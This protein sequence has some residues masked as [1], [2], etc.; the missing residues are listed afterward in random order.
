MLDLLKFKPMQIPVGDLTKTERAFLSGINNLEL[1]IIKIT[2]VWA[3]AIFLIGT[4][5]ALAG[6]VFYQKLDEYSANIRTTIQ[7]EVQIQ[8]LNEKVNYLEKQRK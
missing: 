2:T 8:Y 6:Y 3:T 7:M 5:W 1:A 4:L